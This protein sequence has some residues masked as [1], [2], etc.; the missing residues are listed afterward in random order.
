MQPS[1]SPKPSTA[2]STSISPMAR[3]GRCCISASAWSTSGARTMKAIARST[4]G[5]PKRWRRCCGRTTWSGCTTI[6]CF[7]MADGAARL[8]VTNRIGFFLHTPFVPPAVLHALPR[9]P[10]LL[11]ALCATTS[12]GSTPGPTARPSWTACGNPAVCTPDRRRRL[13]LARPHVRADRRSDRH[14]RR[15][16]RRDRRSRRHAALRRIA[17]REPRRPR[18]GDRRRPAG[19]F[20]GAG[21]PLRGVRT[22]AWPSIPSIADRSAS[23]RSPRGRA[24]SRAAYQ[25]LRRELDRIVG[26]TNGQ[27]SEFDW[28]PLRYMTRAVRR[29]DAGR[30]LPVGAAG[31]VTPLRDGMNLVAKEYVAAQDPLIRAC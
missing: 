14:R 17:A 9:A 8:G 30:V 22:V 4:A 29:A 25:R 5:L 18:A 21:Q 28:V 10:E 13:R 7:P 31:V 19:L 26:D 27:F 20:Q 1:I 11:R 12:S 24:R 23:C 6:I 16:L 15:G 2:R 3:Y